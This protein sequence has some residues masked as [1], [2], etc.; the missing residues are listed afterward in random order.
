MAGSTDPYSAGNGSL[1]RL[2]PVPLFFAGNPR[3]AIEMAGESSRTTHA[4]VDAC[5]YYGGLIVGAVN[6]ASK[7]ELVSD[8][9]CT[10]KGYWKKNHLIPDCLRMRWEEF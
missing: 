9:Y 1:M 3:Q 7:Q 5:R 4:C 8:H 10:I 2:A 6:A